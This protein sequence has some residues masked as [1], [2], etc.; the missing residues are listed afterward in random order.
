[1]VVVAS[2]V[3]LSYVNTVFH[4]YIATCVSNTWGVDEMPRNWLH[5]S[6]ESW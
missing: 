1:M 4:C 6:E 3:C 2:G 5:G